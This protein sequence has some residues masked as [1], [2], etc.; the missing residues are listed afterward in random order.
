ML[1]LKEMEPGIRYRVIT[2]GD[3]LK[4][5]D[6]VSIDLEGNISLHCFEGGWLSKSDWIRLR[7]KVEIDIE[8]YKNMEIKAVEKLEVLRKLIRELEFKNSVG[9]AKKNN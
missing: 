9:K 6:S 7:N 5:G 4:K 3:T 8:H 1:K 2:N